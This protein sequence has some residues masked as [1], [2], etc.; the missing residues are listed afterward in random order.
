[1]ASIKQ[2]SDFIWPVE[3]I[4]VLLLFG[5]S[6]SPSIFSDEKVFVGPVLAAAAATIT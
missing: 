3:M 6:I 4:D 1:M 2:T 5:N